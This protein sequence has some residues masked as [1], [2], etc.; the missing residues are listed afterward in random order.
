MSRLVSIIVNNYDY[1]RFLGE[2][3]DS[4]LAANASRGEIFHGRR[5]R[6][7]FGVEKRAQGC[8]VL[9]W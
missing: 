1:G 7:L 5:V 9:S 6:S 3:I 8:F 4:A 2:A